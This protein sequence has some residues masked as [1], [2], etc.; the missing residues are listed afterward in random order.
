MTM[1]ESAGESRY[2]SSSHWPFRLWLAAA[3]LVILV[4][5]VLGTAWAV[6]HAMIRGPRLSERQADG[7]LLVATFPGKV[8]GAIQE[9][10][11]NFGDAP[12]QLLVDRQSTEQP[13]WKRL[14]P[15]PEDP[16]YLLFSGVE[17]PAKH[18]I[19]RLI[20]V[21]DGATV[22]LWDPDWRAIY[23][24][25]TDKKLTLRGTTADAR[26]MHPV[27]LP[28]GDIIFNTTHSLVRLGHCSSK[29]LW[30]LDDMMHH[31][32][33]LDAEVTVWTPSVATN[34]FSENPWLR[35]RIRD[36][37]LA[38][39]STDGRLLEKHSFSDILRNNGL[40]AL[41]LGTTGFHRN[42]DPVHLNQIKVAHGDS[43]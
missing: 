6:L 8:R 27:L 12:P 29:P 28:D 25:I 19:V 31:S 4:G 7:V 13:H 22:A 34:S 16:G 23:E 42:D 43:R 21:S 3:V 36:D 37:A 2:K 33:E 24:K 10:V 18:S 11:H 40:H 14:F 30:V 35:D 9:L 38:R 15:A 17:K 26:A 41:L 5:V 1:A 32:N 20:R 39:I